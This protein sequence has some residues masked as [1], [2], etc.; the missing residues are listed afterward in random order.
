MKWKTKKTIWVFLLHKHS[1]FWSIWLDIFI[2]GKPNLFWIFFLD[3]KKYSRRF[4]LLYINELLPLRRMNCI[5]SFYNLP[6]C[7]YFIS[8]LSLLTFFVHLFPIY[9]NEYMKYLLYLLLSVQ[10]RTWQNVDIT[11]MFVYNMK[12]REKAT[13]Q[14]N[15]WL[16]FHTPALKSEYEMSFYANEYLLIYFLRT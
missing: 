4:I 11:Y 15:G 13:R 3:I 2:E 9:L 7:V 10:Y 12:I 16:S 1:K 6:L 14:I 5:Q 8:V